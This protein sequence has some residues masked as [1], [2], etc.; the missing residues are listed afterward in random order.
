MDTASNQQQNGRIMGEAMMMVLVILCATFAF[1]GFNVALED[2]D[3][4]AAVLATA[5]VVMA[6][7][8]CCIGAKCC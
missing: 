1:V 6:C 5:C 8:L 2:K 7:I 3:A 4:K